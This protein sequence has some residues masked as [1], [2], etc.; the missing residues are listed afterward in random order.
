MQRIFGKYALQRLCYREVK[1]GF[2]LSAQMVVRC[3][4]K[5]EMPTGWISGAND[6]SNCT[7]PLP[8]MSAFSSVE[9]QRAFRISV[10]G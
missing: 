7:A 9:S 2:G 6:G 3:L 5:V 8:T 1:S 10:D 4:A